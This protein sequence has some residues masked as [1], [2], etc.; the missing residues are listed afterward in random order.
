MS[1]RA[2]PL[3][4]A[5][6]MAGSLF[7]PLSVSAKIVVQEG[8]ED[9]TWTEGMI[10]VRSLDL[11]RTEV[12]GGGFAGNGLEVVIPEGG[13]RG[14]G[15][16]NRLEPAPREAWYR[17]HVRL[18][19]WNAAFKGKLPGLAGLYSSSGRGCIPPTESRPGWSARGLF[20]P[21]GTEGVP[22]GQVPIGTYLYHVDQAG[23]CG[24]DLWW[25]GAALRP[26][27][28][29][30]VEGHV[31][32]NDPSAHNGR[33]HG[34]LDG[35]LRFEMGGI[36]FRRPGE[37]NIGIRHMWH[38]VYFGGDW[39]T[40]NRL[41]LIIDQ[42]AVS[43]HGRVGCMDPFKDDNS[44]LF[45][46]ALVEF[47]ARGLLFGCGYRLACPDRTITRGEAA[48]FF[49]RVMG[50]PSTTKDFFRDDGNSR[51]Q[52]AINRLA[53]EG[54]V[55]GCAPRAFC[56]DRLLTRAEFAA[57]AVRAL[58]LSRDVPNAF[59][60][61]DR[62]WAESAIDAF[63]AAGITR[64][65]APESFCP[66]RR[67]TRGEASAFFVRV[68]D[69]MQPLGQA[70]APTPPSYPPPGDPPVKPPEEQD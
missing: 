61:D 25:Q 26:G 33:L 59:S 54:I 14:L 1:R 11:S 30:C 69:L 63:S 62:H 44:S 24:D 10:D 58:G 20:G 17:Y 31:R 8:F 47:H 6:V 68:D 16:M 66:N 36:A 57:I 21:P 34:W 18:L 22:A 32:L 9:E 55:R 29:H 13:F 56:P 2:G 60:D 64:G 38:N 51:F 42:V 15:P 46:P 27:R 7:A 65:C 52:N 70:S 37:N 5:M 19:H 39:P 45:R 67:L 23:T 28:W 35:K 12:N 43:T 49:H 41:D 4:I 48:A 40:P 53:A 50:L 3:L